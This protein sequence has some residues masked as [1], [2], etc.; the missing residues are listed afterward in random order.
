MWILT[1][2]IIINVNSLKW[3]N[4]LIGIRFVDRKAYIFNKKFKF[5]LILL[6]ITPIPIKITIYI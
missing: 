2:I 5:I 1:A 6:T 3:N 4:F